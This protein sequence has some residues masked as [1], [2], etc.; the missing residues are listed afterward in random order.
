M[1]DELKK[2]EQL[3]HKDPDRTM[4]LLSPIEYRYVFT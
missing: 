3:S 2:A 4:E 1:E